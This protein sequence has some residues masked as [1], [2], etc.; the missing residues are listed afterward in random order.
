MI[1]FTVS[2]VLAMVGQ[3]WSDICVLSKVMFDAL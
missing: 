3:P 2:F 1:Y